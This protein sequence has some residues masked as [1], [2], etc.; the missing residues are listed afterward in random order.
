[1]AAVDLLGPLATPTLEIP[2][3][4][5]RNDRGFLG[6]TRDGSRGRESSNCVR[7]RSASRAEQAEVGLRL[8]PH[9]RLA[10]GGQ[11]LH[12]TRR[13]VQDRIRNRHPDRRP[14]PNCRIRQ[15]IVFPENDGLLPRIEVHML[16]F[17]AGVDTGRPS[18]SVKPTSRSLTM[19]AS[20]EA[21]AHLAAFPWTGSGPCHSRLEPTGCLAL[22]SICRDNGMI[23][24]GRGARSPR[25]GRGV[26]EGG[27]RGGTRPW[28]NVGA[29]RHPEGPRSRMTLALRVPRR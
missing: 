8:T 27:R 16:T 2:H 7:P 10:S 17:A 20:T 23:T 13:I 4:G 19:T 26:L 22:P 5:Q 25:P 9:R 14:Q 24:R 3:A 6:G 28:A 21:A 1:V 15:V 12:L 29:A 11:I 18:P